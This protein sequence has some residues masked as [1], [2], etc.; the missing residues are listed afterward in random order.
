MK[1]LLS[2]LPVSLCLLALPCSPFALAQEPE[3]P[4][5]E[6][7]A[8]EGG[9]ATPASPLSEEWVERLFNPQSQELFKQALEEANASGIARQ[10]VLEAT[11][12]QSLRHQRFEETQSVLPELQKIAGN[13]VEG[14]S[15]I[16]SSAD[17]LTAF[18]EYARAVIARDRGDG[19]AF[20]KHVTEAFWLN[21]GAAETLAELITDHR[22]RQAMKSLRL[23]LNLAIMTSRGN[24]TTLKEILGDKKAL[25]VDFWASWCGPCMQLMPGLKKKAEALEAHGI[26]VVAMNTE[27]EAAAAKAEEVR[28]AQAMTIPWLIEPEGSP[29]STALRIN[30]IPRMVL[31]SPDGKPLYNGHPDSPGLWTSLEEVNP[32]IKAPEK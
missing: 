25:L 11:L 19:I 13:Y 12:L 8:E 10:F 9:A 20:K 7:P 27:P 16:S 6:K 24:E 15:V 28:K 26:V 23:D 17:D 31:I 21:P 3:L 32:E 18:L 2:R 22:Q 29:F 30:S 4:G 5:Q 1:N 14:N